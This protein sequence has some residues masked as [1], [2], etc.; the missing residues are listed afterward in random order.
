LTSAVSHI[1]PPHVDWAD[2]PG[3]ERD[4]RASVLSFVRLLSAPSAQSA[5]HSVS[6]PQDPAAESAAV[7]KFAEQA[8]DLEVEPDE[9]DHQAEGAVPFHVLGCADLGPL[10][11]EVE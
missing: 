4:E 8:E 2:S 9:G 3:S 7:L 10:L 11:D 1:K 6:T 5:L